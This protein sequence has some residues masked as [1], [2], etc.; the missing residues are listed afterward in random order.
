MISNTGTAPAGHGLVNA[1]REEE[2]AA[3]NQLPPACRAALNDST[4]KWSAMAVLRRF[5][6]K[7]LDPSNPDHDTSIANELR[8]I[9]A[10]RAADRSVQ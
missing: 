1:S 10:T 4:V 2:F 7:G 5:K 9:D 8:A 6:V 3:F